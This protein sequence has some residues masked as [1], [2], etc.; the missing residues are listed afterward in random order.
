[1]PKYFFLFPRKF[2][3]KKKPLGLF[4]RAHAVER[5]INAV[6]KHGY[7]FHW[8]HFLSVTKLSVTD[9]IANVNTASLYLLFIE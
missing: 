1:M 3:V 4:E 5:N 9:T 6:R 8:K 7:I 2:S